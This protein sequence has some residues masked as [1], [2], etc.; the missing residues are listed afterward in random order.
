MQRRESSLL[1]CNRKLN[2]KIGT[3]LADLAEINNII[4]RG[5]NVEGKIYNL[6]EVHSFEEAV[7]RLKEVYIKKA[8]EGNK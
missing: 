7:N 1:E 3:L 2:L 8:G 5:A 6:P 4:I